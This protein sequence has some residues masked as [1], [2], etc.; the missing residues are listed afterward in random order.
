MN[1]KRQEGMERLKMLKEAVRNRQEE[2]GQPIRSGKRGRPLGSKNPNAGRKSKTDLDRLLR[3]VA[4]K[5]A[6]PYVLSARLN[7]S[8]CSQCSSIWF[9]PYLVSVRRKDMLQPEMIWKE[10]QPEVHSKNCPMFKAAEL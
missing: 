2:A 9:D 5:T 1:N 8:R 6:E 7:V 3:S 10:G 4:T